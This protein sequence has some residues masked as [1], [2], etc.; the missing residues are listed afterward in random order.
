MDMPTSVEI[1][2]ESVE[3]A[4]EK[5][6][7]ELGVGPSQVIVE[8]IEEPTRGLFGLGAKNARVRL[9]LL[10][11]PPRKGPPKP[12]P[13]PPEPE[14]APQP[15]PEPDP[16]RKTDDDADAPDANDESFEGDDAADDASKEDDE[17]TV[18]LRPSRK[19]QAVYDPD[20]DDFFDDDEDEDATV[21]LRPAA[22]AQPTASDDDA[23]FDDETPFAEPEADDDATVPLRPAA[24]A[25][26]AYDP[27]DD[28]DFFNEDGTYEEADAAA[29]YTPPTQRRR[30]EQSDYTPPAE[31]YA[32]SSTRRE[33]YRDQQADVEPRQSPPRARPRR[34]DEGQSVIVETP[35]VIFPKG[36]PEFEIADQIIHEVLNLMDIDATVAVFQAPPS[37]R[38]E[39]DGPPWILNIEGDDD[40]ISALVGQRGETLTALQ[41]LTRLIVS[42]QT[43][44]R[45]NIIVDVNG[46]RD[47]RSDK[48][49]QLAHRM[50]DQAVQSARTVN[51]EPMPAHE[52][53]VVHMVLR[54]RG[55]V[56][57][58]SKGH[59]SE[60]RVTIVPKT[61]GTA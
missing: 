47:S 17:A 43:E 36:A 41:Y 32:D 7:S 26:S 12:A 19:T 27:D 59:G 56:E 60:R 30:G 34:D 20:D 61:N 53:R 14:P 1:T 46:Y 49:E 8:V 13:Q 51:M 29:P 40:R 58:E 23:F 4:I 25:E 2:A 39:E 44:T 10:A 33:R 57:T 9:Q 35:P 50:A 31:R 11:T 48:L 3:R 55:D 37:E 16:A 54:K 5:G 21:L 42:K 28:D 52:R 24:K 15:E 6:L 22:K 45:A 38:D 18:P